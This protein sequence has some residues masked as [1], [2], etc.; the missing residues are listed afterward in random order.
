[1][2]STLLAVD[3]DMPGVGPQQPERQPRIVDFPAP[4]AP[5]KI[6]VWPV[7]SVKLTSRRMTFSS[8]ARLDV[9]EDDDRPPKARASSRQRRSRQ[10]AFEPRQYISTMSNLV[11]MSP[12]RSPRPSSPR[13]SFRRIADPLR[14]ARRPQPTWQPMSDDREA[15]EDTA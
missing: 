11:T 3:E 10:G 13:P 8:N 9:I 5:R 14:A 7:C 15:E 12:P 4:L 2:P 1:M 6:L